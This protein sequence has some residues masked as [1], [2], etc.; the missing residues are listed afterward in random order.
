MA[1]KRISTE[2]VE[3]GMFVSSLDRPWRETPFLFQGFPVREQAEI[4]EL[5]KLCRYVYIMVPDEEIELSGD[6]SP[7]S[8]D[9]GYSELLGHRHY[10]VTSSLQEELCEVR[11]THADLSLLLQEL[12]A[13]LRENKELDLPAVR[14]SMELMVDSIERN[15][16]AY[17]WL[18]RIKKFDSYVYKESL[19]ASVWAATLG[20]ELGL[21]REKLNSLATGAL[22]MDIGKTVLPG[23][24]LNKQGRLTDDEWVLMKSHVERGMQLLSEHE[25]APGDVLDII[26]THH[27]RLD[28]S[29]YP[30]ALKGNQIPFLGQIAGLI[31]FYVSSTSARPYAKPLSSA[32]AIYILNQQQGRYFSELLVQKLIQALSTYPTGTL[33]ELSSGEVGVVISQNPGLRLKP[34]VVLILDPEKKPYGS[35]PV[36]NLADFTGGQTSNPVYIKAALADGDYGISIEE[37]AF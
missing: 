15:P 5:I 18:T 16:D 36:F 28:G 25:A 37:L 33:V 22:L 17:I 34:N 4:D 13:A 3:I 35:N 1:A 21:Q 11:K 6:A 12:D 9:T 20:R 19:V 26:R 32:D 31:D 29:G 10:E 8:S 30:G 24:L 7:R 14:R 27:E 23:E 2:D